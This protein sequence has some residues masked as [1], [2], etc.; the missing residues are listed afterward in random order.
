MPRTAAAMRV[1]PRDRA[2]SAKE[3]V[4]ELSATPS[5]SAPVLSSPAL[6]S[7]MKLTRPVSAVKEEQMSPQL[8]TKSKPRTMRPKSVKAGVTKPAKKMKKKKKRSAGP[9]TARG[10]ASKRAVLRNIANLQKSVKLVLQK[11]P[12]QRLVREIMQQHAEYE[13]SRF[14]RTALGALQEAAEAYAVTLL[15]EANMCAMHGKRVTVQR[16]D[17]HLAKMLRGEV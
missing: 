4:A 6:T 12:F 17:L 7:A 5:S 15:E 3:R 16:K 1:S 13:H 14:T 9:A 8:V 11:S 2:A 10:R